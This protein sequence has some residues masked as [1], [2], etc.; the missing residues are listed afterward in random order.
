M[1]QV[2]SELRLLSLAKAFSLNTSLKPKHN[3]NH[4]KPVL[5]NS[6]MAT[7]SQTLEERFEELMRSNIEKDARVKY[8]EKQLAQA[9]RNNRREIQKAPIL[10]V[11]PRSQEKKSM[12]KRLV[13]LAK[14]KGGLEG[15]DMQGYPTWTS[16]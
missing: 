14:K 2:V 3:L 16:R 4:K 8:L 13:T 6:N 12:K 10:V 15:I 5:V 1:H 11:S 7:P 9:M